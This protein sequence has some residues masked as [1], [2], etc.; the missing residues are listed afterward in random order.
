MC[1]AR[2]GFVPQGDTVA[3]IEAGESYTL[4]VLDSDEIIL[5]WPEL[6]TC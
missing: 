6:M 1:F 2:Q 3:L 4:E 5:D